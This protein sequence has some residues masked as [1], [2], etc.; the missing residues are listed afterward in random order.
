MPF[1]IATLRYYPL[2]ASKIT[3]GTGYSAAS[4]S[5]LLCFAA[6][7]C[8]DAS[9]VC[10]PGCERFMRKTLPHVPHFHSSALCGASTPPH[11]GHLYMSAP[12]LLP[13]F[14]Y[15][16]IIPRSYFHC[17]RAYETH[18]AKG[19]CIALPIIIAIRA[20]KILCRGGFIGQIPA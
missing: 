9:A 2:N 6:S 5:S 7:S 10:A 4:S 18:V 8:L 14:R 13:A 19:L 20:R 16:Y 3:S 12:P 11:F 17:K 15:P 1:P